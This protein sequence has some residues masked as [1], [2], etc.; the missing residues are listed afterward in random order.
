MVL[1]LCVLGCG[2]SDDGR[3]QPSVGPQSQPSGDPAQS[4]GNSSGPDPLPVV[5][6]DSTPGNAAPPPE[7]PEEPS[8]DDGPSDSPG[9]LPEPWTAQVL[10]PHVTSLC[11]A[12]DGSVYVAGVDGEYRGVAHLEKFTSDGRPDWQVEYP[13][14][15]VSYVFHHLACALDGHVYAVGR[16]R[17]SAASNTQGVVVKLDMATGAQRWATAVGLRRAHTEGFLGGAF[18][19]PTGVY[20]AGRS[21]VVKDTDTPVVAN[22]ARLSL[23]GTV[24]WEWQEQVDQAPGEFYDVHVSAE[25]VVAVGA[26]DAGGFDDS[27]VVLAF[28]LDGEPLWSHK[29]EVPGGSLE[30]TYV[31]ASPDA[32]GSVLVAGS[33]GGW[34]A[35]AWLLTCNVDGCAEEWV[36]FELGGSFGGEPLAFAM[37]TGG[38]LL[39]RSG[40]SIYANATGAQFLWELDVGVYTTYAQRFNRVLDVAPNGLIVFSGQTHYESSD[41]QD[42]SMIGA[43]LPGSGQP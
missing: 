2:T 26:A 42:K 40:R 10:A 30:A 1:S 17:T 23:D 13:A 20:V 27:A 11:A 24:D 12:A 8:A 37:G 3:A 35:D 38:E 34:D 25:H 39:A 29:V 14:G 41:G 28:S 16:Q 5:D 22:V 21:A 43:A 9:E 6:S 4:D 36:E 15:S 18:V 7:A 32:D 31:T 19:A 33:V